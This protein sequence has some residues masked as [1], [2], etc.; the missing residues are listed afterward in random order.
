MGEWDEQEILLRARERSAAGSLRASKA[1]A[2]YL[3]MQRTALEQMAAVI[4]L[5]SG[6]TKPLQTVLFDTPALEEFATGSLARCLGEAYHVFDHRR[7][8]R[9]PNGALLLMSRVLEIEGEVGNFKRPGNITVEYDV[10]GDAWYWRDDLQDVPFSVLMEI[11]LQPCGFLSASLGALMLFPQEDLY[12]R[13]LDGQAR[14]LKRVDLRD[15][16]ITTRARL[17]STL[18]S[19]GIVIQR[20]AFRLFCRGE[21]FFAG[22]SSFGYF[23]A[24]M[25]AAQ[26]GLDQGRQTAPAFSGDWKPLESRHALDLLSQYGLQPGENRITARRL[27]RTD[28]WY[29][30]CHFYQDPVMPGSLGVEAAFQA[31]K[32]LAKERGLLQIYSQPVFRLAEQVVLTWKYRGQ[33]LPANVVMNLTAA[34]EKVEVLAGRTVLTASADIWSD[35]LRIYHL[36]QVSLEIVEGGQ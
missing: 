24:A 22:E 23:S 11:A 5:Q 2:A 36:D 30:A 14:L 9:I 21:E 28:D 35:S 16:T 31:L 4:R 25:M 12:F 29:F 13:N 32:V 10:P 8:P 26:N 33:V 7:A 17:L 19:G 6:Q 1:Q 3:A 34:L 27:M 20:F 18:S 15:Q